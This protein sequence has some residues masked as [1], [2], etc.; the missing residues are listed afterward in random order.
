MLIDS[1]PHFTLLF[2]AL[3]IG[4]LPDT[5]PYLVFQNDFNKII[6][7][8]GCFFPFLSPSLYCLTFPDYS[9]LLKFSLSLVSVT[10]LYFSSSCYNFSLLD[11]FSQFSS[12]GNLLFPTFSYTHKHTNTYVC[13]QVH[14]SCPWKN[15]DISTLTFTKSDQSL[16]EGR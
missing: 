5:L 12:Q 15:D 3:K 4:S 16:S 11:K 2:S 13:T 1:T 7:Q 14:K 10:T 9:L 6:I 8:A